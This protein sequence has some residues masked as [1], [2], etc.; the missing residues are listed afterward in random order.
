LDTTQLAILAAASFATSTL[1]GMLGLAGGMTLLAIL[2]LFYDP[3]VAIPL[4][5]VIQLVSNA[6]RAW[7][8][9]KHVEGKLVGWYSLLLLP[10]GFA[11]LAIAKQLS[12]PLARSLIGLFVLL[13]TWVPGV[14]LLGSHPECLQR[15]RRFLVLG[16]VVGLFNTTVGATGPLTAP[17]FLNLGL[18]RQQVIGTMAACQALGHLAKLFVFGAAGFAF[19]S[20]SLLLGVLA[21]FVVLGSF[22]GSLLLD[23]VSER[24]FTW[25]YKAVLTG[26][27]LHLVISE[28]PQ[29]FAR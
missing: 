22:V 18:G 3:L 5:G 23:R 15:N 14:M 11:G 12:P 17:F 19:L 2:L 25:I 13:A 6:S 26:L 4:H 28:L 8:Q 29:L 20:H 27:A 10:M 1:S 24:G 9:R 16:G 7:I 21:I